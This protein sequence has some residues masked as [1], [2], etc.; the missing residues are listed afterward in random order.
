MFLVMQEQPK[1]LNKYDAFGGPDCM[2]LTAKYD[3]FAG[4]A[5]FPLF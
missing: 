5:H 2:T 1:N 3:T 4:I